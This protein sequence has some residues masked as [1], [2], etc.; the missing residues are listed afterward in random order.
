[1]LARLKVEL[2]LSTTDL[3]FALDILGCGPDMGRYPWLKPRGL[4]GMRSLLA[5]ASLSQLAHDYD[6]SCPVFGGC[7][8]ELVKLA[9][10]DDKPVLCVRRKQALLLR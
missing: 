2:S 1:V 3:R 4:P 9:R 8:E 10:R 7:P 6:W 5:H